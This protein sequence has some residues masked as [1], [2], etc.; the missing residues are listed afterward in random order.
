[1]GEIQRIKHQQAL[2]YW[3]QIL[4]EQQESGLCIKAFCRSRQM[5]HHAMY[6]W[7]KELRKEAL[8]AKVQAPA[9]ACTTQFAAVSLAKDEHHS[10]GNM[11]VHVG[12]VSLEIPE[13]TAAP[14]LQRM[15]QVLKEVFLC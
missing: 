6:Y 5:S 12:A 1:M 7:L 10:C 4:K 13:G 9:P 3:S 8:S 11:V 15:L 14:D 2:K